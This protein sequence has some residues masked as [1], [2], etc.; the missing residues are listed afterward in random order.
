MTDEL[1]ILPLDE[2]RRYNLAGELDA[3]TANLLAEVLRKESRAAGDLVL[4]ISGVSFMD[5]SGV[6]VLMVG[7]G[8]LRDGHLILR[9]PAPPI[10]SVFELVDIERVKGIRV[11]RNP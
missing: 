10:D 5:S 9:N 2:P 4:D 11:E 8:W 6:H 1:R 3:S 7:S